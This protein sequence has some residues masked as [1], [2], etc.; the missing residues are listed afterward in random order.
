MAR[1]YRR[2]ARGR[3]AGGGFSGQSGGR[4]ARLKASGTRQGGGA[5]MTAARVGGTLAKPRGLKPQAA[6]EANS[7]KAVKPASGNAPKRISY[8]LAY[9]G[10]SREAAQA[11]RK[12]GYKETKHGTYGPGVYTTTNRKAAREYAQWR[13]AG[14]KDRFGTS[15]SA[16]AQGPAVLTH[17]VPKRKVSKGDGY[18]YEARQAV[19]Q[20]GARRLPKS[21]TKHQTYLVMGQG[22]ADRTLVRQEGRIRRRRR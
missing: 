9:H 12:G 20:G 22:L 17:R 10:T 14:G 21:V 18:S 16:S 5:K 7:G 19:S 4:G 3:F 13:S 15:F 8:K 1:K 11:I 6:G 2:D